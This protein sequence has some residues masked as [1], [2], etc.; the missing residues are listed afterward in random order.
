MYPNRPDSPDFSL[1]RSADAASAVRAQSRRDDPYWEPEPPGAAKHALDYIRL[2]YRR[3]VLALSAFIIIAAIVA[4]ATFTGP[5]VYQTTAR[6]LLFFERAKLVNYEPFVEDWNPDNETPYLL[7]QSRALARKALTSITL[8]QSGA[9]QVPPSMRLLL[10]TQTLFEPLRSLIAK[11]DTRAQ[12]ECS[13]LFAKEPSTAI[14]CFLKAVT[15]TPVPKTNLVDITAR[16]GDPA[17][18]AAYA[19]SLAQ[20]FVENNLETTSKATRDAME[21]MSKQVGEQKQRVEESEQALLR[22][23]VQ[24]NFTTT[25]Q[26]N[27]AV[28]QKLTDTS[29]ALVRAKTERLEKESLYSRVAAAGS[30]LARLSEIPEIQHIPSVQKVRAEIAEA[31]MRYNAAA[32]IYGDRHPELMKARAEQEVL[33][34]RLRVEM[35]QAADALADEYR[36]AKAGEN[37]LI[38]A[39]NAQRQEALNIKG[40]GG[41]LAVLESDAASDKQIYSYLLQREK[42]ARIAAKARVASARIIDAAEVPARPIAR[43]LRST[44]SYSL[45]IGFAL[46]MSLVFLFDYFDVSLKNPDDIEN[47]LGLANLGLVPK[48]KLSRGEKVIDERVSRFVE[49]FGLV[50]ANIQYAAASDKCRTLLITSSGPKEGKT[51]VA[52]NLAISLAQTGDTVLLIDADLRRP[53]IHRRLQMQAQPGLSEFILG[54]IE[55]APVR[56]TTTP[57]LSVVTSGNTLSNP[58]ELLG[59]KR[60]RD[61]LP[62]LAEQFDWIILDTPPVMAVS[63]AVVLAG[64]VHSV[65]FV[66][67]ADKTN[68]QVAQ[69]SVKRL[70]GTGCRFLGAVLNQ[71]NLE[72]HPYYYARYYH[73]KYDAYYSSASV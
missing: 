43:N 10:Y 46:S 72:R 59:A 15:V 41:E 42:E 22:R 9:Q 48:V 52:V 45:M 23:R 40:D 50:R 21:W 3:R 6:L 18:A 54:T 25:D 37:K 35:L 34:G 63:D 11:T 7:M 55:D 58:A 19:N 29:T 28:I 32:Q 49:A 26:A 12:P 65:L 62:R 20:A 8:Q 73:R 27:N 13:S 39:Y 71:V 24:N 2:V 31:K 47:Q 5:P 16:S 70:E 33:N 61:A 57:G 51:T 30:D 14:D 17:A 68:G 69:L 4:Q 38:D 36:N 1:P 44:I 66:V 53:D 64:I 56:S 67:A 60:F